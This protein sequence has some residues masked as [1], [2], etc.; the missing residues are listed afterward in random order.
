MPTAK[1][2]RPPNAGKGRQRGHVNRVTKALKEMILGA[3]GDAGD[4]AYLARQASEQ[5]V[6]FMAL[7]G[8]VLPTTL[9][10]ADG[11]ALKVIHQ[12][13]LVGVSPKPRDGS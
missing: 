3:L 6:A 12:I 5:P 8:K 1:G 13:N 2:T 11:G 7:L 10:G 9:A 4:Q